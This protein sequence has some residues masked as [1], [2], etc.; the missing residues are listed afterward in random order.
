MGDAKAMSRWVVKMVNEHVVQAVANLS[1]IPVDFITF[2]HV[3]SLLS[4]LQVCWAT[5]AL[6]PTVPGWM[7]WL[8]ADGEPPPG[9]GDDDRLAAECALMGPPWIRRRQPSDEAVAREITD[10]ILNDPDRA[11]GF[12]LIH[13]IRARVCHKLAV[14]G[15]LFDAVL[16]KVREGVVSDPR[17]DIHLDAGGGDRLPA[18]E[19][20]FTYGGR[21]YY[22]VAL[23][24][25]SEL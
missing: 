3:V 15:W 10:A 7:V 23:L 16:R 9:W 11:G 17:F 14:H 1:G 22:L 8:T 24:K 12:A 25:R 13:E 21:A 19:E 6:D 5:R 2:R 20:P 4:D 18:S